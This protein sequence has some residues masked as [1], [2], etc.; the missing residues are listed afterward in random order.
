MRF[1]QGAATM[2]KFPLALITNS[3]VCSEEQQLYTTPLQYITT[4]DAELVLFFY[5]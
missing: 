5:F 3:P 4:N 2:I 1:G